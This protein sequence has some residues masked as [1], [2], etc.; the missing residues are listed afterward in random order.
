MFKLY[1]K[2]KPIQSSGACAIGS[3][4][5]SDV[6]TYRCL[7]QCITTHT[8]ALHGKTRINE[9]FLKLLSTF[10]FLFLPPASVPRLVCFLQCTAKTHGSGSS[11]GASTVVPWRWTFWEVGQGLGM[12]SYTT[13]IPFQLPRLPAQLLHT[14]HAQGTHTEV[15]EVACKTESSVLPLPHRFWSHRLPQR[16]PSDLS[17]LFNTRNQ[18]WIPPFLS[19]QLL[20]TTHLCIQTLPLCKG[21]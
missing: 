20:W 15:W 3:P 12:E 21:S 7:P 9:I 6:H 11:T 19:C 13:H 1:C 8:R 18:R 10:F 2:Q 16:N 5:S 4:R 14:P 17:Q